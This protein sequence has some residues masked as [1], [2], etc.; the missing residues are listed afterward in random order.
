MSRYVTFSERQRFNQIW[1]WLLLGGINL[2]II[3]GFIQQ[4]MLGEPFGT[5]PTSDLGATLTMLF[6]LL[7]SASLFMMRLNTKV[8]HEGIRYRF[9][10]FHFKEKMIRWEDVDKAY[11][12]KYNPIREYGGWGVRWG[13]YGK[14][15]A[16]NVSGNMGLQLV[17]KSGKKVLFG[18][19]RPE[20]LDRAIEQLGVKTLE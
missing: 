9:V 16:Y 7:M 8:D 13:S 1:I 6:T 4:V 14:G 10:P 3:Y 2:L 20:E 18:T 12:R 11:V 15:N 19:Q 17:L 5:K